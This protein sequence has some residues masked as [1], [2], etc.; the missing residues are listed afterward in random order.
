MIFDTDFVVPP[1][2]DGFAL[3]L[4]LNS[5]EI[6]ILGITTVAGNDSRERA[7][8]DALR[9]LEI[10]N[11]TDIPVYNGANMPLVHEKSEYA[12]K[13]HG[14]WWSD[15]PPPEP[16]GGFAR[17]QA[18]AMSAADFI[19]KT[20][21]EK[22]GEIVI[23]AIGPL[24]NVAIALRQEPG[25]AAMIKQ[26]VIMGGAVATLP[27]G[28]GN[29][30][31][32]AEFNFWVDPE[33]AKVVLRSG[34]PIV[35]SPLNVSRKAEFTP[36]W[37]EKLV[38]VETPL[39]RMIRERMEPYRDRFSRFR[40]YMY[41]QLAVAWLIDPTLFTTKELYVDVD[42]N[43]DVNYGVSVGGEKLW[44]GAEGAQ[45]MQVQYD[46]D[47]DRFI[48]LYIERMTKPVPGAN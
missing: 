33:A 28:G 16:P 31:P 44:P 13:V 32:N 3:I 34:V 15:D 22:P 36:A 4:A 29:V 10:A 9:V 30:T 21:K 40:I 46:V 8:S 38:S 39:T 20:V 7:T 5:P 6:H 1:Q 47:F 24:T 17:K 11:R 14:R 19:V 18:E 2:D 23:L 25:L 35:L 41:D 27:D 42:I 26:I 43:H 12:T 45:K 48:R 37:Y